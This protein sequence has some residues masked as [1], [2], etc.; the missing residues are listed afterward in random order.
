MSDRTPESHGSVATAEP[1]AKPPAPPATATAAPGPGPKRRRGGC[2]LIALVVVGL[3]VLGVGLW[4]LLAKPGQ[5]AAPA[6]AASASAFESAMAKAGV[7]T[8]GAPQKAVD[9]AAVQALGSHP[10]SAT[11]TPE[12]L[13]ALANAFPHE[14]AVGNTAVSLS[15]IQVKAAPGGGL[16]L[17]ATVSAGGTSYSG[18]VSGDVAVQDGYVV[19]TGP[20]TVDA[21][22]FTLPESQAQNVT[23]LLLAYVNGYLAAA[24]GLTITTATVTADGVHVTGKAPDS[25]SY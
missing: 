10:F 9:L 13:S 15:S 21:Q 25:I 24:P 17:S 18:T 4:W 2:W 19:A 7:K 22:G 20:L 3:A 23:S 6:P 16:A 11:F 8:P 5:T 14:V 12:E 1:P